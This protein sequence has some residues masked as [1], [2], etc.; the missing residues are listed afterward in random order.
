MSETGESAD[1][2]RVIT[3]C[4]GGNAGHALAVV[5]SQ[6]F[7][8]HVDWLVSSPERADLLHGGRSR[9]GLRST[10]VIQAE[11]DRLRT[12]SSDP[13]EVIPNADMVLLAVPAFA[14][15]EVLRRIG[16]HLGDETPVGC[17]PTRGGF[18]FEAARH[19]PRRG[20]KRQTIFGL[21]TLPWSTRIVKPGE[22]VNIGAAKAE[23]TIASLPPDSGEHLARKL[24][25]IFGTRLA[26][27]ASFLSLTLG[28]QGQVIH[29][30]LMYGHFRSWSGEEYDADSVPFLY[31]E[32]TDEMGEVV[33]R[34]SAEALAVAHALR[35]KTERALR[36]DH[37][38]SVH[39]WLRASYA[40]VTADSSTV[41]TCFR[42]GPIQERRTP[43]VELTPG[44]FTPNFQYRSLTED[45][46][47]GLVITR[48]LADIA[49]VETPMIDEVISWAQG[50]LDKGYLADGRLEGPDVADLPTPQNHGIFS[51]DELIRWYSAEAALEAQRVR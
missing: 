13:A 1:E 15:A 24:S 31:A 42:T 29:T 51:P 2:T 7:T 25:Q 12:I 50:V 48:A 19:L 6:R 46:P 44:R 20:S 37:V 17:L 10:G 47:Y 40:H 9:D 35:D 33:E 45:V 28:N 16:T 23:G 8:A 49:A 3:I 22:A 30:G 34:M 27:A 26:P 32:A 41:A 21:Q 43:M 14:H 38:Q 39:D 11:A 36:L 4:G 5:L 18:E